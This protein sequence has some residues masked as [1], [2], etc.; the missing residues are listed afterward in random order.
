MSV[1][2]RVPKVLR[3]RGA[4]IVGSVLVLLA[5]GRPA[6]AFEFFNPRIPYSGER[7]VT[8]D[9]QTYQG[10]VHHRPGVTREEL[11][12]RGATH[13]VILNF[14]GNSAMMLLQTQAM[15]VEVPLDQAKAMFSAI[16]DDLV[17]LDAIGSEAV[18]G[19][20]TTRYRVVA[21]NSQSQVWVTDEGIVMRLTGVGKGGTRFGMVLRNLKVGPQPASMFA[22]PPGYEK[23]F[24]RVGSIR[25]LN[26]QELIG[27]RRR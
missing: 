5:A 26:L 4:A 7:L 19:V 21:E 12:Y 23:M 11:T 27:R 20:P 10:R 13:T 17:G 6:A 2:G 14:R 16:P 18:F 1:S 15:A 24:I 22:M 8:I 3:R 25:G 9:G